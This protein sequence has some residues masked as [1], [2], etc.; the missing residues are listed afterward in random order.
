MSRTNRPVYIDA[1]GKPSHVTARQ[2]QMLVDSGV[3][4]PAGE[5]QGRPCVVFAG[6]DVRELKGRSAARGFKK[7]REFYD[8]E[9]VLS[10]AISGA[11][12]MQLVKQ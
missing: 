2:A 7:Q 10:G 11:T 5:Y 1:E 9:K 6:A 8:F 3:A 4:F 12:G